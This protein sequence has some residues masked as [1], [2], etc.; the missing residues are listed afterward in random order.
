[1][2]IG[3]GW[4]EGSNQGW[5]GPTDPLVGPL[6]DI[7][8]C[9]RWTFCGL[10]KKSSVSVLMSHVFQVWNLHIQRQAASERQM[11]GTCNKVGLKLLSVLVSFPGTILLAS[12]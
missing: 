3:V 5:D 7:G 10:I 6:C 11:L 1:M 12:V 4:G 2:Y 9:S 8:G